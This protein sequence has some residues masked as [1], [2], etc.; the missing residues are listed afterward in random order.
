VLN[1]GDFVFG[2]G[3][4]VRWAARLNGIRVLDNLQGTDF[5]PSLLQATADRGY[6]L[7]LLGGNETTIERAADY[8]KEKFP[9][10][11][12]AGF[13]HGYLKTP[14]QSDAVLDRIGELRPDLV[15]VGMGNPV[16]ERW[17]RDHR[18]RVEASLCLGIGGLFDFWAGNVSRA[19]G[20]LQKM[21]H[22]WVWRLFQQPRDKA[23]RYL[24]GNPLFLARIV[25]ERMRRK[26]K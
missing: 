16:Q 23:R 18:D 1:D 8:V 11:R 6:S 25:G 9:G 15:L 21:G 20:W 17:I 26:G 24:V 10:W 19:P 5:T 22:E 12:L 13:H 7:F 4:G 2:D 14:E 3:T